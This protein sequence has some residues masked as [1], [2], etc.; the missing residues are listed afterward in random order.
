MSDET[1]FQTCAAEYDNATQL[2]ELIQCVSDAAESAKQDVASG[3]DAFFLIYAGALVL[4]VVA[5]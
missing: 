1:A 4:Y 3:L 2:P 5:L